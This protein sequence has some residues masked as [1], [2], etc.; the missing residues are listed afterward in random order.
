ML[1]Y[2]LRSRNTESILKS[3]EASGFTLPFNPASNIHNSTSQKVSLSLLTFLA[4]TWFVCSTDFPMWTGGRK[5]DPQFQYTIVEKRGEKVLYDEVTYLKNGKEKSIRGYD[6]P[7]SDDHT[8]F[9][10]R[11]KGLLAI[12]RSEW[13]V[14]LQDPEGQWAVISFSKTLFTR[15]G[16]DIIFRTKDPDPA[17]LKAI[18]EQLEEV[19][20]L[21]EHVPKLT[22]L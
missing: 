9:T 12:A 21:K 14:V 5:T 20:E 17:T 3:T 8:A 10:W 15:E 19:P 11:G 2:G 22:D 7:N 6:F 4:G 1:D 13:E 18:K 16:V